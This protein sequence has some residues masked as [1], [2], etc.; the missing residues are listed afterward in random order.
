MIPAPLR[1]NCPSSLY[2]YARRTRKVINSSG[3]QSTGSLGGQDVSS[4]RARLSLTL[5]LETLID[6]TVDYGRKLDRPENIQAGFTLTALG[7]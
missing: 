5:N 4:S 2:T 3:L 6:L 1:L 7:V